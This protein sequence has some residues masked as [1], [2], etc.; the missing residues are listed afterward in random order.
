MTVFV[1]CI[2]RNLQ[3]FSHVG[4][5][6]LKTECV[7]LHQKGDQLQAVVLFHRFRRFTDDG[8][9]VF[10]NFFQLIIAGVFDGV[11]EIAADGDEPLQLSLIHI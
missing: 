9:A 8:Q 7:A 1:D 2:P 10:E 5:G 11:I 4:N 6:T 3:L